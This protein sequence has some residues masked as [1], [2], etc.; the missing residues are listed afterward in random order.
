MNEI[1]VIE[2]SS[3]RVQ[4]TPFRNPRDVIAMPYPH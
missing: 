1:A 4:I 2:A 3:S